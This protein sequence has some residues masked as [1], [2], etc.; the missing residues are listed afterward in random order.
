MAS[1]IFCE[2]RIDFDHRSKSNLHLE[3]IRYFNTTCLDFC[4]TS[5]CII[6]HLIHNQP[7]PESSGLGHL[8]L[9][10]MLFWGIPWENKTGNCFGVHPGELHKKH[11]QVINH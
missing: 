9:Q 2:W 4:F 1:P 11:Y 5:M 6:K 10:M 8:L 7:T 3:K